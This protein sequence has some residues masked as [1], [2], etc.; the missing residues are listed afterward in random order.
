MIDGEV[1]THPTTELALYG[2]ALDRITVEHCAAALRQTWDEKIGRRLFVTGNLTLYQPE[3]QITAAYEASRAIAVQPPAKIDDATFAY[4]D[5]GPAGKIIKQENV[6][7]L[8][9]TLIE[10]ANGVRLNLKPTD[11]EAGRV[12]VNVR[13][14]GG[15]LTLPAANPGLWFLANNTFMLG[16]LGHHSAD[17]LPRL[18]AGR[19]VGTNFSTGNDAFLFGGT[20]DRADLLLQLQII[21]AFITDPGFRPEAMR[22]FQKGAEMFYDRLAR[23][24]EGPLQLE[25]PQLLAN[26]DPRFGLPSKEAALGGTLAE[27]QA[28]LAPEFARGALEVAIVGD[29]DPTEALAAA[30]RTFGAL[31]PRS[32]KPSYET[33][34]AAS[35][36]AAALA[37]QF[38]TTTE[39]PKGMVQLFWEA[40][41]NRDVTLARQLSLLA[42][43]LDDRLRVK[44]REEMGD[45]YSPSAGASL[46]DTFHGFG[47]LV[48][49]A[50]VAPDK[51]RAVADAMR[52]AATSLFERGVT[53]EE[54]VR[55]KQPALT[56]IRQSIRTN[57]YWLGSVL[58][59]AQEQPQRLEWARTRLSGTEAITAVELTALAKR[60][61]NPAKVHEF[62]SLPAPAHV[63]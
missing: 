8:D 27:V 10:F 56:A 6:T 14:S 1:F 19:T 51:A 40:T 22:Q 17:D 5:F 28:W 57:P 11:F 29:F 48:A 23:V 33:Q 45:T 47:H 58:G 41:D 52:A 60:Y 2:P 63:P 21:C 38:I 32:A 50:T 42:A 9:V 20:T 49:Q 62:L 39:I 7:D 24:I 55:A 26:G 4:T 43:V 3:E 34:R 13:V 54:L 46:S 12:R 30:A 36:P 25:V 37:R 35:F 53:D 18:L 31:A 59:S 16:G 15:R 44:I 61:L